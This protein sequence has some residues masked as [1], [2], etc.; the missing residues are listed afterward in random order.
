VD[1]DGTLGDEVQAFEAFVLAQRPV[2]AEHYDTEYFA[3]GWRADDNRYDLATRRRVEAHNPQL[4][5]DV[6]RPASLLDVGCGPGFL[7]A[8][9]AELGVLSDGID[10]SAASL[11]LAPET[12][13]DRIAIG[14]VTDLPDPEASYDVVVCRE[15]LEHLTVVQVRRAVAEMCRVSSRLVYVTTRFNPDPGGLLAV[16]TEPEVDPTHITLLAKPLL[17]ALFVLEGFR[18]RP[19]LEQQLDWGGKGRVLVLERVGAG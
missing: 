6:L 17:R 12:V 9:L 19:D 8:L 11:E 4:I 5:A 16:A 14:E 3:A 13:R 15:V 18:S 10:F 2:T 1:Y 7:M